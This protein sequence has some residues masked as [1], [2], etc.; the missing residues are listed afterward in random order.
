MLLFFEENAG[1]YPLTVMMIF[2][3]CA[4]VVALFIAL[5]LIKKI[6]KTLFYFA[7][8]IIVMLTVAYGLMYIDNDFVDKFI[9]LGSEFNPTTTD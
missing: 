7:F 1:R 4:A 6:I 3:G 9:E 2:I 8:F 5:F